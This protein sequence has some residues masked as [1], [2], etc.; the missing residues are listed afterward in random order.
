MFHQSEDAAHSE[1]FAPI[2]KVVDTLL[3][4]GNDLKASTVGFTKQVMEGI[5]LLTVMNLICNA[6]NFSGCRT[7]S[8]FVCC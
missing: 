3:T 1:E 6:D 8:L 2:L 4:P 5:T 7:V